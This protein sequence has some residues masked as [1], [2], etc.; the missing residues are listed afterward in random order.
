MSDQAESVLLWY[1]RLEHIGRME[2]LLVNFLFGKYAYQ[3][4]NSNTPASYIRVEVT[5]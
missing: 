3:P 1:S 2:R 4:K 5:N